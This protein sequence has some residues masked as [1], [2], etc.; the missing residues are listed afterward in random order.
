MKFDFQSVVSGC[1]LIFFSLFLPISNAGAAPKTI[2]WSKTPFPPGYIMEGEEVGRGY[3]DLLNNFMKKYLP[4]YRHKTNAYPNWERLIKEMVDGPLIC[5]SV[6]FY[7]PPEQRKE[8]KEQFVL[9]A[10]SAVFFLHDVIVLKSEAHRFGEEVSFS[11]LLR[12]QKLTFGYSRPYG[13]TYNKM[14]GEYLGMT[15]DFEVDTVGRLTA[16]QKRKNIHAR[17]SSNNMI[18]GMLKML[19]KKRVDWILEYDFMIKFEAR[20][21]GIIDLV[22]AIP[23]KET[24]NEV[25]KLAYVCSDTPEGR[26]AIAAINRVL[27]ERRSTEEYKRTLEYIV[28]ENRKQEYWSHYEK[29]LTQY[30]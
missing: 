20:R 11:T 26:K 17:V 12:N 23:V 6:F 22:T 21:L 5:N 29:I 1:L 15:T 18:G 30:E 13:T 24:R 8:I 19:T 3:G 2:I 16:L 25:P 9:S 28:P 7:R 14:L 4:Q 27:K 10:P